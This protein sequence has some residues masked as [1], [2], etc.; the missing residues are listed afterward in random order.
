MHLIYKELR[1]YFYEM[2]RVF[3]DK[4][5]FPFDGLQSQMLNWV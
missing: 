2:Y 5:R 4:Q 3:V 1:N